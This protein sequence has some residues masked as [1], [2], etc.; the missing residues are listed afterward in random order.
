MFGFFFIATFLN[1]LDGNGTGWTTKQERDELAE[2]MRAS[3]KTGYAQYRA[4]SWEKHLEAL[5]KPQPRDWRG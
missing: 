4:G 3:G 2:A 1:L 5:D